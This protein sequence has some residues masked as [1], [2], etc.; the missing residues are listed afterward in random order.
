MS[1]HLT[2]PLQ[3]PDQSA[4]RGISQSQIPALASDTA[5]QR[6]ISPSALPVEN[7]IDDNDFELDQEAGIEN[8]HRDLPV[9]EPE[10]QPLQR[11][12]GPQRQIRRLDRGADLQRGN[13]NTP[14]G[15]VI[16]VPAFLRKR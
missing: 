9:P 7:D 4:Q 11:T 14:S 2:G 12:P 6:A 15:D 13:R 5:R 10:A 8:G 16:D 3:S 1:G